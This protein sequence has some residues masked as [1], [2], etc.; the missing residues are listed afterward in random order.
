MPDKT[1]S[2][3]EGPVMPRPDPASSSRTSTGLLALVFLASVACCCGFWAIFP[4]DYLG[5]R[6]K[7]F[8]SVTNDYTAM[9]RDLINGRGIVSFRYPPAFPLML[10][11]IH[12][13][14]RTIGVSDRL[15]LTV[16]VL[17]SSGLASTILF[18]IARRLW[19]PVPAA[20]ATMGWITYPPA[21]Y[22][23][24]YAASETP[25]TVF[26]FASVLLYLEALT[27]TTPR[28]V[29]LASLACGLL[30][31]LAMLTRPLAVG[32][33]ALFAL[34]LVV[35]AR[36]PAARRLRLSGAIL[37]LAGNLVA[38][39]PWEL[40][41]YSRTGQVVLLSTGGLPST[42]D[43]LTYAVDPTEGRR[44]ELPADVRDLQREIYAQQY[45][46]L[47]SQGAVVRFL[48]TKLRTMP[49]T[50]VKLFAIKAADCWYRSNSTRY[51]RYVRL[52]QLPYLILF[53]ISAWLA[54][55]R[56]G[57]H[58]QVAVL[59]VAIVLYTWVMATLVLSILRYMVP[60]IGL[61]FSLGP[62]LFA[63]R[64]PLKPEGGPPPREGGDPVPNR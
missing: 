37:I 11:G 56:G 49:M 22:T 18:L 57:I 55:S 45:K 36:G 58:R 25:F 50:V 24:T 31:G 62:A 9:V 23:T 4:P 47:D 28:R 54:W 32:I 14:A 7:D 17:V 8:A 43:G 44:V 15:F 39:T 48:A 41:M 63:G 33:G 38:V 61:L 6:D 64:R 3:A 16:F 21:L 12:G 5:Q 19:E 42:L 29:R 46:Q 35:S 1:D 26:L 10:A 34:L 40:W 20:L 13:L 2:I 51:D 27:C 60:S 52:V 53:S 59:V 30:L